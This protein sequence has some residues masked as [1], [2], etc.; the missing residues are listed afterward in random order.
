MGSQN[1]EIRAWVEKQL[2]D[3]VPTGETQRLNAL[4]AAF[5]MACL[6]VSSNGLAG[7]VDEETMTGALL[8]AITATVP[9]C[10]QAFGDDASPGCSW[11][12]YRKNGRQADT[13]AATGADFALVIRFP[14]GSARLAVFQ[15][16]R[17]RNDGSTLSI[18][19]LAPALVDRNKEP[20]FL[21]L[22]HYGTKVMNEVMRVDKT[23]ATKRPAS[24]SDLL[25][26]HYIAY[27]STSMPCYSVNQFIATD[28][29]YRRTFRRR[30]PPV[31]LSELNQRELLWLLTD[32]ANDERSAS[33]PGWLTLSNLT[34][35]KAF[36]KII[37]DFADVYEARVQPGPGYKP[38]LRGNE[39]KALKLSRAQRAD[40]MMEVKEQLR[41]GRQEKVITPSASE[42]PQ[43]ART[44]TAPPKQTSK[45]ALQSKPTTEP[46]PPTTSSASIKSTSGRRPS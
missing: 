22:K 10:A 37:I 17:P 29:A 43:K 24:L 46:A 8:G 16:K 28:E 33:A 23:I 15:A 44:S 31:N 14:N 39:I 40:R 25:W 5:Q 34:A 30:P 36:I 35:A 26:V 9:W 41:K 20:Q 42:T 4:M 3:L 19:H 13:E 27:K 21:R 7:Q 11:V 12:R 6:E 38:L 1:G 18:H 45:P 32:G 2:N